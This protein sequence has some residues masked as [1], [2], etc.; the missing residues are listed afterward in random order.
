ML[1]LFA[2]VVPEQPGIIKCGSSL[3]IVTEVESLLNQPTIQSFK[4]TSIDSAKIATHRD[5]LED[6]YFKMIT[7]TEGKCFS[8][9]ALV[10]APLLRQLNY[11]TLKLYIYPLI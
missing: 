8:F 3:L 6:S 11:W 7:T 9:Q 5:F 10:Y 4:T 2:I 1:S